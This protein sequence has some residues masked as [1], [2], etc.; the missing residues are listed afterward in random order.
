MLN[1]PAV[2][3]TDG[4]PNKTPH[5]ERTDQNRTKPY[6]AMLG[7]SSCFI[8]SISFRRNSYCSCVSTSFSSIVL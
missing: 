7:W 2:K 1:T 3:S 6:R 8:I 5:N 4:S